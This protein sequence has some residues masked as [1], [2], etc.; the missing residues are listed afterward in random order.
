M[1]ATGERTEIGRARNPKVR[2][3]LASRQPC[4]LIDNQ[5]VPARSGRTFETINPAS[6]EVLAVVAEGGQADVDEA[7]RAARRAF[8]EGPWSQMGPADRSR[9]LRR[10]AGLMEEHADELAE[11]ESLDN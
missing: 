9:L 11:L 5:W 3:W 6:E 7:V 8:E 2:E 10:F 4:L 1:T